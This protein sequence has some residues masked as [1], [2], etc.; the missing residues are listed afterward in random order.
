MA[1]FT[2]RFRN[3]PVRTKIFVGNAVILLAMLLAAVFILMQTTGIDNRIADAERADLVQ[4]AGEEI[5]LALADRTAAFRDYLLSAQDTALAA[6]DE[7]NQRLQGALDRARSGVRDSVQAERLDSI[8]DLSRLWNVEVAQVGIEL[9]RATLQ[10]GGPPLD[11]VVTFVQTGEGRRGAARAREVLRRFNTR[12]AA[13]ARDRREEMRQ[14]AE[15]IR[16]VAWTSLVIAL[17]VAVGATLWIAARISKPLVQAVDF[18]S[19]VAA[20]DLTQQLS[21]NGNDEVGRLSATLNRMAA[22]LRGTINR[23]HTATVQVAASADQIAVTS[24]QISHTVDDQARA[25]EETS[26]SMEQIAAQISRVARSAESLAAS[27]EQ[28]SSSIAQMGQ[29]IETTAGSADA[30]GTSVEQT[31]ATIEEMAASISQVARHVDETREIARGAEADAREGSDAV[32]RSTEAMRR[33][34]TEMN[35]LVETIR[36]LGSTGESIGQISELIEDIADQTHLLALNAAIEA[37]RAGEHGRG[38][39]VVA[40]EIRRLAER[41][42]ESAREIGSTIRT[43]RTDVGRAVKSTGTVAE[44]TR[45]GIE[46]ADAAG[47]ALEKIN[48]SAGRTRELMEEVSLATQQQ[49]NAAEQAQEAVRHIQQIAEETRIATREQAHGSRQIVDAVR[50]MNR[51]TQEV[52][53]ATAE[54]KRGGDL[55]LQSTEQISRGARQ[56]QAAVQ[57]VVTAADDLSAQASRL[58]EVVGEFRV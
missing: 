8:A 54:Q 46:L 17:V 38:F 30:L 49:I 16:L 27:V 3:L 28:T 18:A 42:V 47:A 53:A 25:T 52:F 9:R 41:S 51:Q 5:G 12:Q 6:F 13:I 34:H 1:S 45:G 39:S 32:A 44:R 36:G 29:S 22:D 19:L 31:S 35:E 14:V 37:A 26:S 56:A 58:S 2:E 11:T 48:S 40:Q 43:V 15:R 21:A 57:E 24:R 4:E 7:A 50:N 23:V 20:G 10:P 33:I 55:I